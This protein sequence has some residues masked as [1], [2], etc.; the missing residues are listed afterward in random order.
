MAIEY[1]DSPI[2]VLNPWDV[3]KKVA[4]CPSTIVTC[5]AEN[6]IQ[7]ALTLYPY[8]IVSYIVASNGNIPLYELNIDGQKIGLIL[9]VVGAPATVSEYEELFAMGVEHIL[10][11]GTCG[12][13][14]Q[15]IND[16]QIIIPYAAIREEGTSYHYIADE[17]EIVVN[18]K[19]LS[20]MKAFFEKRHVHY[21]VAKT[22]TTDAFYRETKKKITSMKAKGCVCVD[23]ECS[24]LAALSQFRNK[25][26][27]QFFYS[28]DNLDS[29]EYEVRSLRNEIQ[30]D[31]K[32]KVVELAVEL[33]VMLFKL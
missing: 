19:T 33:A 28:A 8:R 18:H 2:A 13:L 12:V 10:V 21:L 11:F 15:S 27:A 26:I 32:Q 20:Q 6:L 31:A 4:D 29:E 1:D 25:P 30:I 9:S 16:C 24:A 3:V 7:Y 5:F 14:D 23:M 22:W 17:D